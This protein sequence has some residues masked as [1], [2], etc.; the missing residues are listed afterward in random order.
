IAGRD[1][2]ARQNDVTPDDR[3][4]NDR[5][6]FPT[7]SFAGFLP[8]QRP[9]LLECG[10]HVQS[11]SIGL[12]RFYASLAFV[13]RKALCVTRIE[14]R[15]VRIARPERLPITIG[16]LSR[17]LGATLKTR[18]DKTPRLQSRQCGTIVLPVFGLMPDRPFPLESDP[19]Q[20]LIDRRFEFRTAPISIDVFDAQKQSPT[21][22]SSHVGV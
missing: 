18:I 21:L 6:G 1:L 7:G 19:R 20:I 16:N 5:S 22:R 13:E 2:F 14:R 8:G 12:S 3:I 17:D 10:L 15:S 4:C 9:D 11:Q